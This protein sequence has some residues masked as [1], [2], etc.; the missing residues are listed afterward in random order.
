[1]IADSKFT[2]SGKSAFEDGKS[3]GFFRQRI[4]DLIEDA[5]GLFFRKLLQIATD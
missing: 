4:V 1:M 2:K 3:I 5:D